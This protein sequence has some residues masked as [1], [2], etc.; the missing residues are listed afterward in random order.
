MPSVYCLLCSG[1]GWLGS[2]WRG[3]CALIPQLQPH[4]GGGAEHLE[5]LSNTIWMNELQE[6]TLWSKEM[7]AHA[8]NQAWK[9]SGTE[10]PGGLQSMGSQRV[11]LNSAT[12]QGQQPREVRGRDKNPGSHHS[13]PWVSYFIY[14]IPT[15]LFSP[16]KVFLFKTHKMSLTVEIQLCLMH[17]L[18]EDCYH[19]EQ[20]SYLHVTEVCTK[21]THR[22]Q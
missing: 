21:Q 8:S 6:S 2:F 10:K 16:K 18:S 4:T 15:S 17:N 22:G 7:A 11:G 14:F 19:S 13:L 5:M 3:L 12:K 20:G 9:I 1:K